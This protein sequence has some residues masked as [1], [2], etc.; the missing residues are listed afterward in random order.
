MGP[1]DAAEPAPPDEP[2]Y[3]NIG[4]YSLRKAG[5]AEKFWALDPSRAKDAVGVLVGAEV[6]P[7][8]WG[9]DFSTLKMPP[10][11]GV[12]DIVISVSD[13][14]AEL[15]KEELKGEAL[16][17][18]Y[19]SIFISG[20]PA[21]KEMPLPVDA[22]R[23]ARIAFA[24]LVPDGE[25]EWEGEL[26]L[27][28]TLAAG[29][30][31]AITLKL[32]VEARQVVDDL[33][34]FFI[35]NKPASYPKK[36]HAWCKVRVVDTAEQPL[37]G[38]A[39]KVKVL[40]NNVGG[41][42]KHINRRAALASADDG[43]LAS[44]GLRKVL[45]LPIDYPLIFNL[46]KDGCVDRGHMLKIA[47]AEA[48]HNLDPL[49]EPPERLR[50]P[51]LMVEDVDL[52][53]SSLLIDPGHGVVYDDSNR[54]SQEW[55]AASKLGDEIARILGDRFRLPAGNV[56]WTRT[57]G[58]G[59]ISAHD[60]ARKSAPE[61]GAD[62][63]GIS[64]LDPA[65]RRIHVKAHASIA[66]DDRLKAL[67]DLLSTPLDAAD[68]PQAVAEADRHALLHDNLETV[69]AAVRRRVIA[70]HGR[71]RVKPESFAWNA[72]HGRCTYDIQRR[73]GR[74]WDDA[75]TGAAGWSA[76]EGN[77]VLSFEIE[78][79]LPAE[80][81]LA[82]ALPRLRLLPA[83]TFHVTDAMMR[84]LEDRSAR[85]SLKSE[86]GGD[87]AFQ[88]AARASMQAA[89]ALDYMKSKMQWSNDRPTGDPLLEHGPKGWN[90][91]RRKAYFVSAGTDF[92]ISIHKNGNNAGSQQI[93]YAACIAAS[94]PPEDARR[95]ARTFVKYMDPFDQGVTQGG[96]MP[97]ASAG[98]V[99]AGA[100]RTKYVYF[101][102]EFMDTHLPGGVRYQY[103][104]ML[105]AAYL[106]RVAEQAVAGLVEWLLLKQ[107]TATF[108]AIKW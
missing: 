2:V 103:D 92:I 12:F 36:A 93:G 96:V 89:G 37:G 46:V 17:D 44:H 6:T 25:S 84:R 107:D 104:A 72:E 21:K 11:F 63:F 59:L 39:A 56:Y 82:A 71:W 88:A 13:D 66:A 45:G 51:M 32:K 54:R 87:E 48:R 41:E 102:L 75:G 24:V 29:G 33:W 3:Q 97:H 101:E 27:E 98:L 80:T 22:G 76:A 26:T 77:Y 55:F 19:N 73:V 60:L 83:D 8:I 62:R 99:V 28:A 68:A 65:D 106:S 40:R 105:S 43:F 20:K 34:I 81:A 69:E 100:H 85:W 14:Y 67:S 61:D 15:T 23:E 7:T 1:E 78:H 64:L 50:I 16:A 108:D 5:A 38:V 90:V 4:R 57:A 30:K 42:Y 47:E 10:Q 94:S 49:V 91:S 52:S 79:P 70:H 31:K 95:I 9:A 53:A 74:R 35:P 18:R 58:F 86:I